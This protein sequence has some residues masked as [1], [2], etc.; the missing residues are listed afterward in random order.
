MGHDGLNPSDDEAAF[1]ELYPSLRR[2]AAVVGAQGEDP[3][4]LVHDAL[5]RV[6]RAGGLERLDHPGAYLRRTIVNLASDRRRSAR[7]RMTAL[8]R[9]GHPAHSLDAHPSDLG[10]LDRLGPLDRAVLYLADVDG[11][12]HDQVADALGLSP[13]AVRSRAS[14]AR[15][16]LRTTIDEETRP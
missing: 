15:R 12:G 5:V 2:F 10:D 7:R 8:W 1:A 4:D 3:D 6:L 11:L 16:R 9:L 13:T 14:R